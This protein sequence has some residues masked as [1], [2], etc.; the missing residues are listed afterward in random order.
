VD[1]SDKKRILLTGAGGRVGP[2]LLP[3][4]SQRYDL[5]LY[6]KNPIIGFENETHLGDLSDIGVLQHAMEGCETVVHLAAT[7]DEADFVS[8]LVPSNVIGLYNVFEAALL[9]GVKRIVFAS[10]VHTMAR[11]PHDHPPI[12]TNELPRPGTRY[13]ITKALGETMGRYY[14]DR[15]GLEF[16][17]LRFGA[18]EPAENLV[19]KEGMQ[20]CWLSPRDGREMIIRAV[21]Q[22]NIGYAIVNAFS[23]TLGSRFSLKSQQEVLRYTAQDSA[24]EAIKT[25]ESGNNDNNDNN[26][27]Y[28]QS[29]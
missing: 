29:R 13:G 24:E 5:V 18:F 14:F 9:A 3:V 11:F 8:L 4:F 7:S 21:E 26:N 6:D 2:H 16:V 23:Q 10:S 19:G 25:I 27:E 15:D 1:T 12:E 20:R 22:E 17:A 28:T